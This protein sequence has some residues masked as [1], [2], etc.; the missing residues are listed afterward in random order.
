MAFEYVEFEPF[1]LKWHADGLFYSYPKSTRVAT[2]LYIVLGTIPSELLIFG[3]VGT[4]FV[5]VES[6]KL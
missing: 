5:H 4:M 1:D 6:L 2:E 3:A